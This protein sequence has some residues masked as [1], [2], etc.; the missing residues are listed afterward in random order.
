MGT[1]SIREVQEEPVWQKHDINGGE[2][3]SC[4]KEVMS[5]I[6][7]WLS[8]APLQG[9]EFESTFLLNTAM[10]NVAGAL[11]VLP[12]PC[13]LID[14][15][16]LESRADSTGEAPL[17]MYFRQLDI[18]VD[19]AGLTKM[20]LLLAE[21]RILS[22]SLVFRTKGLKSVWVNGAT[23]EYEPMMTWVQLLGQRRRWINGMERQFYSKKA[24]A[25]YS[26]H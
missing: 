9:F 24:C 19:T 23:F 2:S 11:P 22:F 13:Q 18:N 5:K 15:S 4:F 20:S 6:Y 21:D 7:W 10:F 25:A 1:E 26:I 17:D 12:G 14:W 8:P 16:R 3:E